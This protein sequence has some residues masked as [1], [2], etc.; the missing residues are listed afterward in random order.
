MKIYLLKK[1]LCAFLLIQLLF[2]A[3]CWAK[4][5]KTA[6]SHPPKKSPQHHKT[7]WFKFSGLRELWRPGVPFFEV[8]GGMGSYSNMDENSG[9]TAFTRVGIGFQEHVLVDTYIGALAGIQ[10]GNSGLVNFSNTGLANNPNFALPVS[11]D[12]GAPIDILFDIKQYIFPYGFAEV[13]FGTVYY[14]TSFN[15]ADISGTKGFRPELQA[16]FGLNLNS[17]NRI[18]FSY[19]KFYGHSLNLVDVNVSDGTAS[20]PQLPNWN[21]FLVTVDISI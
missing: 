18:T 6:K 11:M 9:N 12:V 16:A 13:R 15:N 19:Q 14:S 8:A 3:V 1:P 20:F 10:T 17:F 2:S 4:D 5:P 21:A 7:K